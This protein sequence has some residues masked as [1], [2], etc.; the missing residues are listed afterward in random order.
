MYFISLLLYLTRRISVWTYHSKKWTKTLSP[1]LFILG[2]EVFSQMLLKEEEK[3]VIHGAKVSWYAPSISHLFFV[4]DSLLF[5][6][7][8]INE[9]RAIKDTLDNYCFLFGQL[10]NFDKSAAYFSKRASSMRKRELAKI[11]GVR[12]MIEDE[13]YLGNPLIVNKNRNVSFQSLSEN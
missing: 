9:V 5:C 7:A 2:T 12:L 4:D 3:R 8:K 6:K 1:Y 13:R 10:V 11:L